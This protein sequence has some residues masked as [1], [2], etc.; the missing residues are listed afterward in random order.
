MKTSTVAPEIVTFAEGVRA[1]LADLP[2]EEVDDL[3]EGLEADLAES[4]AEDL[5]RTL[6]DPVTYAAELRLAAGLPSRA[7]AAKRGLVT[8]L[9]D[10]W[11]E[12]QDALVVVVRR[13]AAL[14]SVV[15]FAA[16]LRPAWWALRALIAAW[17][18]TVILEDGREPGLYMSGWVT[19]AVATVLSVQWGRGRWTFPGMRGVVLVGNVM[20][21]VVVAVLYSGGWW[22]SR[23]SEP[24]YYSEVAP[25]LTGVYLNGQ[26]VTNIFGYDAEGRPVD[27]VQ[28]FDQDGNP[29]ATSVV[30]GNGCLD[31]DCSAN[32]LWAPS[33]LRNGTVAWNVFP[34]RMV[35]AEDYGRGLQA[36]QGAEPLERPAPFERV[37][38]LVAAE[39]VAKPTQ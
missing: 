23:P 8:G 29:L 3:T 31:P 28:L 9:L 20:T 37:P 25:D 33:T 12:T 38:A 39:T 35:E 10:G 18:V 13:N 4:L 5:R 21:L 17:C 34:M 26:P 11:R 7:T 16:S 19:F 32:G 15:D 6:P 36:V 30:G 22:G 2:A 27:G 14:S 1:A 24:S